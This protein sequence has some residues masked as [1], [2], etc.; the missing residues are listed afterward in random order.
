MTNAA[1][2][3]SFTRMDRSTKEDCYVPLLD[4]MFGPGGLS[5]LEAVKD[6]VQK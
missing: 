5:S 6:A 3:A 2:R 4:A 1:P